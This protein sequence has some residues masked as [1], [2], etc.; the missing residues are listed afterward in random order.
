M[1]RNL[2]V[3]TEDPIPQLALDQS[4]KMLVANGWAKEVVLPGSHRQAKRCRRRKE[5]LPC[6]RGRESHQTC[7]ISGRVAIG[8]FSDW[9]WG[10]AGD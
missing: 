9:A 2:Y 1:V 5:D 10:K 6:F 3:N 7:E 4:I 8:H